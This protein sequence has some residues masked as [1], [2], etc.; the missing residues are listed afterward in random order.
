MRA[1]RAFRPNPPLK[2]PAEPQSWVTIHLLDCD[3]ERRVVI[4]PMGLRVIL[5]ELSCH[6]T[7]LNPP[8]GG[9][10]AVR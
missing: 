7:V 3:R 9:G 5:M 10:T 4:S 6:W 1:D 8:A 2:P